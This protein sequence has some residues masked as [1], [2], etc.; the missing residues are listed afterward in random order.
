MITPTNRSTEESS[1][2]ESPKQPVVV[3]RTPSADQD[4]QAQERIWQREAERRAA[5]VALFNPCGLY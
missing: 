3:A 1:R 2:E 5:Y 4:K